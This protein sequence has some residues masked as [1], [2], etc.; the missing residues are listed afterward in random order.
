[1][2]DLSPV[3]N[4]DCKSE[5]AG[6][7][8]RWRRWLKALQFY[9]DAKNITEAKQRRAVLLHCGGMDLQDL[10]ETLTDPGGGDDADEFE[11]CARTLNSY[12][13]PRSN[14]PYERHV[15]RQIEQDGEETVD[16]FVARLQRQGETCE[17]GD[18]KNEQVRDQVIEK[19]KSTKLRRKLLERAA[20]LTL[21]GLQTIA[22]A[23]EALDI[24][25]RQMNSDDGKHV[26]AG[27]SAVHAI[28]R[29]AAGAWRNTH[30]DSHS[31][32]RGPRGQGQGKSNVCFR[33]GRD[34]HYARDLKCPAREQ[35]CRKCDFD[36]HFASMCRTKSKPQSQGAR[37]KAKGSRPGTSKTHANAVWHSQDTHGYG[38]TRDDRQCYQD[39]RYA[40]SIKDI[41]GYGEKGTVQVSVGGVALKMLID[42][43]ATTNVIDQATWESLKAGNIKC[44][45]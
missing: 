19:C 25:A 14:V 39:N 26:V 12:F 40:F 22:R 28:G 17:F 41:H 43:G 16:Q 11:K 30:S 27:G 8:Q 33:C 7:S 34:D 10:Y 38:D 36:G 18:T 35:K 21:D 42:S 37:P 3:P 32:A 5:P 13:L 4:F 15:F 24:Q 2:G 31:P 23:M 44:K 9:L 1:M 6:Q 45:S 29:R 20:G